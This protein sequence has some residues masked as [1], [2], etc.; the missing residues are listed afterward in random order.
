MSTVTSDK[1]VREKKVLPTCI[2][3]AEKLNKTTHANIKCLYCPFEAC[4]TCCRTYI[5]NESIV[6]CMNPECGREWTRKFIRDIFPLSFIT[7]QL[8]EHR[9]NLLFQREQALLPATQ[10]IIEARNECK[11]LDKLIIEE[12]RKIREIRR[13]IQGIHEEKIRIQANPIKKE[14]MAFVRACPDENC[15]GFLSTAWKCGV[16]EKWTCSECHV[17]KG[18][19]R[20]DPHECNPDNVATAQLLARDTKPCPKCGEGIFK[21]DGCF[22]KDTSI[23][24]YDGSIKMSQDICIGDILVGDDGKPRSVLDLCSGVDDLYKVSQNNGLEYTVNSKHKLVLKYCGDKTIS[25]Q[26]TT[27]RWKLIW[28][29]RNSM[30]QKTK[31]FKIEEYNTK[32]SAFKQ[33]TIYKNTLNFDNIIE[34]TIEEYLK[35][36]NTVKRN[37]MGYKNN[38]IEYNSIDIEL[39]PYM[40]G[41][42]L[43]DGTHSRPEIATN[44]KEIENYINKWCQLNRADFVYEKNNKYKIRI[45]QRIED[46]LGENPLSKLL[47]KYNLLNNKHIPTDYLMNSREVR[48]KLLAGIIDTDG[49][50]SSCGKRVTIIQTRDILSK[51]IMFLARSLGFVVNFTIRERKQCVIFDCEPKDYKNQYVINISGNTLDEIPTLISRKKCSNSTPNKDYLR[52]SIQ[53]EFVGKGT[54]YGWE[55]N[56]NHRF[57]LPDFTVVRNCDQMWCTNCHTAFSWRTGHIEN[58]IHNPHYYEWMRRTNNGQIPREAG[59]NPCGH[60]RELNHYLYENISIMIRRK[61]PNATN[62]RAVLTTADRIIRNTLHLTAVERPARPETYDRRNQELR[63]Q[64]LAN[65]ISEANFKLQLQR[66]DKRHHKA[67]EVSGIFDIVVNVVTDIMYRFLGYIEDAPENNINTEMFIEI[68]RIVDYANECLADV[69]KTYGT[70]RMVLDYIVRLHTGQNAL[71]KL[72]EMYPQAPVETQVT[73]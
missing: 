26:E 56:D 20:E 39:D 48:L 42:W 58:R 62:S 52:T 34:I 2:I 47:R 54:Y 72:Q 21:I 59:D 15:R 7:G 4:Q 36:D 12:E 33:A 31:D 24:L 10:P 53:V 46:T 5:L 6:K 14:R 40:L 71:N 66:D 64:Y 23:L 49:S 50:V 60:N 27:N 51:Q 8:K 68:N 69:S 32:E 28:L 41:I 30:K 63:V 35:L 70:T 9:E 37:L 17:V 67:Q 18:Y 43:G 22:V 61:H 73:L 19:T 38:C 55:I 13:V 57:I 44:D 11:R 3:C 25:W 1:K 45:K 16:C 29:D 65:E